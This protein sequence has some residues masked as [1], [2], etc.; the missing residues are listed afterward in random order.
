[1]VGR[2]GFDAKGDVTGFGTYVWYVWQGG[3]FVPVEE[4]H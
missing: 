4:A 3:E 2:V 1:V